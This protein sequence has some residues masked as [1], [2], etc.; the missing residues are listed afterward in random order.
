M[1]AT[2]ST[3]DLQPGATAPPFSL[4]ALDGST[5]C[6]DD[7]WEARGLLVMF[8]C[9]HCPYVRHLR[10][11]IAALTREY[12]E[13]GIAAVA[14]ASNDVSRYPQD[15]PEGMREEA[16]EAG[17]TFP[18]LFDETQEVARA[19]HAACTPDFFLFDGDR[20]LFYRGRFD[21]SRPG[22]GT[23]VTGHDLRTALD[24]LL[25]GDTPP[26]E[27]VPSIGCGIKWR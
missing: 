1:A 9:N 5:V 13:R 4:P 12:A 20:R 7:F 6:L 14:I 22:S 16:E 11:G 27:Q 21:D 15:G 23:P 24:A 17:Y 26:A 3:M 19:Y 18:Y 10:E 2:N 8:I 25:A